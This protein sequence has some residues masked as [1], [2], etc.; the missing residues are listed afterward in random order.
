MVLMDSQHPWLSR[1][2]S[3]P[4]RLGYFCPMKA[5]NMSAGKRN[6]QPLE[7]RLMP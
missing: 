7:K 2:K 3:V 4:S 1:I 5:S 6:K